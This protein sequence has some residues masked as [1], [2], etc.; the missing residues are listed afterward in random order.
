M[1][2]FVVGDAGQRVAGDLLRP[3]GVPKA[4]VPGP[5]GVAG[6]D[7]GRQ[8]RV[9]RPEREIDQVGAHVAQRAR[10]K[11]GPAAPVE[12]GVVRVIA[13][14]D[15]GRAKPGRPIQA[16]RR[17]NRRGLDHALRPDRTVRPDVHLGNLADHPGADQL[18]NPAAIV[19]GMA[20]VAHLGH[21]V[22][23]GLGQV[24]QL[25]T[26]LDRVGQ[27][28]LDENVQAPLH[29]MPRRHRMVMVGCRDQDR[30]DVA[31]RIQHLAVVAEPLGLV[32]GVLERLLLRLDGA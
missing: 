19:A 13:P 29:R 12:V 20:L 23:V 22:G 4:L 26:F 17:R 31:A 3:L 28:L 32:I 14:V 2:E 27:R 25:A 6:L 24:R 7:L 1:A 10:A 15:V 18:D 30:V 16:G 9:Q 21:Q 8:P 11:R 5:A